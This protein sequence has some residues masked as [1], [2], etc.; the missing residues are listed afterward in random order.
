MKSLGQDDLQ[1]INAIVRDR[2][3]LDALER[4]TGSS[5][6]ELQPY[7]LLTNFSKYVDI[8][9]EEFKGKIKHGHAMSSCNCAKNKL[10]IIHFGIGSPVAALIIELLAFIQPKAVLFLGLCGGLRPEQK[11]G[12]YFNAVAAIRGEGTSLEYMPPQCPSLS[13]FVIQRKVCEEIERNNLT[14]H[15]GVIHTTNIRF[16]EFKR[17]FIQNLLLE[18]VQAIDM[19][20]ATLFTVGFAHKVP[21]GALLLI[22]DLPLKKKIKTLKLQNEVFDVHTKLQIQMGMNVLKNIRDKQEFTKYR[23]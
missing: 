5:A 13:S 2:I 20:S 22:A 21:V 8:F 19:E 16:W 18:Q 1:Q 15:T 12:D 14:Y 23:F 7:I 10:S 4:Y 11:I 3:G 17:N 6:K 9:A